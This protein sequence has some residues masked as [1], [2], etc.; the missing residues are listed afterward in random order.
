MN[1][2]FCLTQSDIRAVLFHQLF[3]IATQQAPVCLGIKSL[4][5]SS[6]CQ[7]MSTLDADDRGFLRVS[8]PILQIRYFDPGNQPAHLCRSLQKVSSCL[9]LDLVPRCM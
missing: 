6:H 7:F 5:S 1:V 9:Q 4:R 2:T 8:R 3:P